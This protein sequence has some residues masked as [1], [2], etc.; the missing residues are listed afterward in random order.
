M[1]TLTA[2]IGSLQCGLEEANE[3]IRQRETS[4]SVQIEELTRLKDQQDESEREI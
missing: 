4:V 3:Q 2:Q 1:E